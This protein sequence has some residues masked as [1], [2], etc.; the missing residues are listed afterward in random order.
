MLG[1]WTSQ[2]P[3]Y[4]SSAPEGLGQQMEVG[5]LQQRLFVA[6]IARPASPSS[7]AQVDVRLQQGVNTGCVHILRHKLA[8]VCHPLCTHSG[9]CALANSLDPAHLRTPPTCM[10]E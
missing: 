6:C 8:P 2:L 5:P 7:P 9:T 10:S 3:I 4:S 1:S